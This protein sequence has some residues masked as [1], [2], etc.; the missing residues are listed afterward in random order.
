MPFGSTSRRGVGLALGAVS[1][2]CFSASGTLAKALTEAGFGALEAVWIRVAGACLILLAVTFALRGP[3]A[4]A[5]LRT[6]STVAR[7]VLVFGLVVVAACQGLYFVAATRL[8][9]G[10]AILLEYAGPVLVVLYL[11]VIRRQHLR[12]AA[13]F[14]IALAMAGLCCVVQIW[15][16]VKLDPLGLACGLGAAAGNAAYFLIIDRLT[17]SIDALTLTSAGMTIGMIV[18]IPLATPWAAPWSR[19]GARVALGGAHPPCWVL[20]LALIVFSTVVSYVVGGM[21]VQRLSAPVAAAVAYIEPVS[22]SLLAWALLSQRLNTV[23]IGGGIIVLI[24]AYIAQRAASAGQAEDES[25]GEP[26]PV[27]LAEPVAAVAGQR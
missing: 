22:A 9:V 26:V 21:A 1:S 25:D 6:S 24:G 23:Q 10:V 5:V 11:R 18:L 27:V 15:S 4:F 7:G 2:I 14:G 13:F 8:P 19:L 17:G 3:R 12:P 16:G 20:V